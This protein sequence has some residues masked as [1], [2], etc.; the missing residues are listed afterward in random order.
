MDDSKLWEAVSHV[1]LSGEENKTIDLKRSCYYF[2]QDPHKGEFVK[3]V[4]AIANS[5]EKLGAQGYVVIG[6]LDSDKC[7]GP[8]RTDPSKYVV[9]APV[10]SRDQLEQRMNQILES[11]IDPRF[12]IDCRILPTTITEL[13]ESIAV[14]VIRGWTEFHESDPRPY[15]VTKSVGQLRHGQIFVRRGTRSVVALRADIVNL[16]ARHVRLKYEREIKALESDYGQSIEGLRLEHEQEIEALE[17][18]Y[19]EWIETHEDERKWL[20]ERIKRLESENARLFR[21]EMDW[22]IFALTVCGELYRALP[23]DS[24]DRKLR[25]LLAHCKKEKY[26]SD[27]VR[28]A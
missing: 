4:S 21:Q 13:N 20:D 24:R 2:E 10:Q 15:V 7:P 6:V 18:H 14:L 9:G 11:H 22:R 23:E 19:N 8:N 3:D 28:E 1:V 16:S 26:Y 17:S 12:T 5:L 25:R 27:V